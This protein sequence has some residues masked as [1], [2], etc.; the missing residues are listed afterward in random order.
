[1]GRRRRKR[2]ARLK[3]ESEPSHI[4]RLCDERFWGA[5]L[6]ERL[7]QGDTSIPSYGWT[8][9]L[10]YAS[11]KFK[12][13]L[14][15]LL[16]T[17]GDALTILKDWFAGVVL[18]KS[19]LIRHGI[20]APQRG[21]WIPPIS[22]PM[23]Q[24]I[25]VVKFAL[26]KPSLVRTIWPSNLSDYLKQ[27]PSVSVGLHQSLLEGVKKSM[28]PLGERETGIFDRSLKDISAAIKRTFENARPGQ[29]HNSYGQAL[30]RA[31]LLGGVPAHRLLLTGQRVLYL[32]CRKPQMKFG[33]RGYGLPL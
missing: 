19:G 3:A 28:L 6:E 33:G 9:V 29:S 7:S 4:P 14:S 15:D 25:R 31:L 24:L 20:P 17:V 18:I 8:R 11:V 23:A 30:E 13:Y 16:P 21:W 22:V 32:K 10:P 26:L 5:P 12:T 27:R 1:L 2:K